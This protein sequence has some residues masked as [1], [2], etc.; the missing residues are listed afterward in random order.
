M[1]VN[2]RLQIQEQFWKT[3]YVGI[4][5]GIGLKEMKLM[6]MDKRKVSLILLKVSVCL[7]IWIK[8]SEHQSMLQYPPWSPTCDF[9]EVQ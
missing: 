3:L 2:S 1:C 6:S 5:Q 9:S 7:W 4:L 8:F